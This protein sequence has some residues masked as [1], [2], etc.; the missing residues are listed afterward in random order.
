[1]QTIAPTQIDQ[2]TRLGVVALTVA[3]L[4]R[5]LDYY[6]HKLGLQTHQQIDNRV[7]LGAGEV[8]LLILQEAPDLEPHPPRTGLYHYAILLPTRAA[9]AQFVKHLSDEKIPVHGAADHY[10]SEAIYM[11]DPDG[12][13]IEVYADRPREQWVM[14]NGTYDIGT[15]ALNIGDLMTAYPN[16]DWQGMPAGA[17]MGHVHLHAIKPQE[18]EAFYREVLG[19]DLILNYHNMMRFMS[20]GGYHHHVAI[21]SANAPNQ[22]HHLG[23]RYYTVIVSNQAEFDA[24]QMRLK[25]AA[26]P[27][28][29]QAD[30]S[31]RF[32]DPSNNGILLRIDT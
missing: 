12:H 14:K 26:V 23:L 18:A 8:D 22:E 28:E 24:V 6:T 10:V 29:T 15:I 17:T 11:E 9:L 13:G 7:H 1:M 20:A 27:F 31:L 4:E 32:A 2:K 5:S 30:G 16:Q 3:N 21:Q 19:I 25:A